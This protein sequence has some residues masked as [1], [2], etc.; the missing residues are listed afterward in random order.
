MI[1][2]WFCILLCQVLFVLR[3]SV[4]WCSEHMCLQLPFLLELFLVPICIGFLKKISLTS[5]GLKSGLLDLA[6]TTCFQALAAWSTSF[7]S[8]AFYLCMSLETGLFL[9]E[10][11][12]M[13]PGSWFRL[14]SMSFKWDICTKYYYWQVCV[15]SR[16][17]LFFCCLSN[18]CFIHL[19]TLPVRFMLSTGFMVVILDC[20]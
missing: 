10:N 2:L 5:V 6:T 11:I 15:N 7:V 13:Y 19:F 9:A 8:F 17:L 14:L 18:F 16:I 3:N 1:V 12:H 20:V 4:C